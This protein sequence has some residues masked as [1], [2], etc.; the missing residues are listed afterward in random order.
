MCFPQALHTL[1]SIQKAPLRGFHAGFVHSVRVELNTSPP[2]PSGAVY[3]ACNGHRILVAKPPVCDGSRPLLPGRQ[4]E[5]AVAFDDDLLDLA[6]QAGFH[7]LREV[8][9]GHPG[10]KT[11]QAGS[12]VYS[13]ASGGGGV[14]GVAMSKTLVR[15]VQMK[16]R[17]RYSSR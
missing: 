14:V 3:E 6:E 2:Q 15:R 8:L 16:G 11:L 9:A 17:L 7:Q 13:A 4:I 5:P 10:E 1:I 12:W